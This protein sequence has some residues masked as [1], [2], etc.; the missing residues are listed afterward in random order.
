[1][2]T[3]ATG[4]A[5]LPALIPGA[6]YT[7]TA[8]HRNVRTSLGTVRIAPGGTFALS[9]MLTTNPATPGVQP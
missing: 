4:R 2:L 5:M 1:V 7:I 3:D 8:I 9:A 6:D